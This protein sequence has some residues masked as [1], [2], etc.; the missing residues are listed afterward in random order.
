MKLRIRENSI[1]L[2]LSRTE[3]ATFEKDGY[4]E[5][6]TEFGFADFVYGM[7]SLKGLESLAATYIGNKITVFMPS[8]M[9]IEWTTTDAVGFDNQMGIGGG[10]SLYILVE[11]DWACSDNG[12]GEDQSDNFPNPN[13][14]C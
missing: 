2:R 14:A 3:V 6:K 1:R 8:A 13:V 4:I 5:S 7:Q 9:Q 10:K 12:M 11:K